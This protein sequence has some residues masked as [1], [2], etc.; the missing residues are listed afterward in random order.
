MNTH[1]HKNKPYQA[2]FSRKSKKSMLEAMIKCKCPVCTEG[3]M[4]K[5]GAT[6]LSKFNELKPACEVCHFR[7]MPE[8]GFY[9]ISLYFT[10]AVN[11]AFFLVFGFGAYYLFNDPPLWVYYTA[12]FVPA[13][14]A[15][16]WNLRYSKVVM[17]YVFGDVWSSK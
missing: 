7:F 3:D 11:V 10:Y 15:T 5:T 2:S 1:P 6:N 9:Q 17:L 12:I 16:P 4:F 13:I 14:L 8:P